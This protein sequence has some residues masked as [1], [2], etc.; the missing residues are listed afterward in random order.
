[1]SREPTPPRDDVIGAGDMTPQ[2]VNIHGM[3]ARVSSAD[4]RESLPEMIFGVVSEALRDADV[5]MSEIDSIVIAA[6]DLIDGR[7]LS[8]MITG[9][10]AGAYLRDEIRVSDDAL[11][12]VS[13]GAARI[14]AGESAKVVVAS[15]GRASEGDVERTAR[16]GFDPFVEQ[17]VVP[18]DSVISALRAAAYLRDYSAAGREDACEARI[19][20]T[21]AN[22]NSVMLSRSPTAVYPLRPAEVGTDADLGAAVVLGVAPARVRITGIGHG[23]DP[24]LV[25]IRS[26]A[27]FVGARTAFA[28]A[29][30]QAGHPVAAVGAVEVVA[31]SLF[32]EIMLLEA[33]GLTPPGT[34]LTYYAQTPWINATGGSL[35]GQCYPC[36]GLLRLVDAAR[37][38]MAAGRKATAVVAAGS[39][40]AM[41]T[42]T[43]VILEAA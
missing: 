27:E 17:P 9:P 14:Q 4:T 38:V 10:A 30:D 29:A 2:P 23:T 8:S 25:G 7:S 11:V 42:T 28:Q 18:S 1:M 36:S 32:E 43:A 5:A 15:W 33:A 24:S 16:A 22:P 12:A 3:A 31:G 6:H 34:G 40:V 26:C 13:L 41:Q 20:R 19:T 35:A 39:A 37:A 21:L